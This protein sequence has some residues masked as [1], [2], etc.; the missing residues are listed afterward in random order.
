MYG[1][2]P[3]KGFQGPLK[4]YLSKIIFSKKAPLKSIEG[5]VGVFGLRRSF[6]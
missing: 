1:G 6:L 5:P 2:G 4:G 3:L